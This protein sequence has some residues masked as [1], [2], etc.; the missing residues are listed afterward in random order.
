MIVKRW[1][2]HC[3]ERAMCRTQKPAIATGN[4]HVLCCPNTTQQQLLSDQW[5]RVCQGPDVGKQRLA[6]TKR[7]PHPPPRPNSFLGFTGRTPFIN[8][9]SLSVYLHQMHRKKRVWCSGSTASSQ[10]GHPG[11]PGSSQVKML[12]KSATR[13]LADRHR[14]VRFPVHACFFD[15]F[16]P[17]FSFISSLFSAF[18]FSHFS[19]KLLLQDRQS[20]STCTPM[21]I[22][23]HFFMACFQ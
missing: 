8:F 1:A 22:P 17:L 5:H 18:L 20:P 4:R 13:A 23:V 6:M 3:R 15:L 2:V 21:S 11:T 9:A 12:F 7:R 16:D 14:G 10:G 19:R